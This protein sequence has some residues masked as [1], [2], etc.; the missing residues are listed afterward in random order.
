[1]T[2]QGIA[3]GG[4]HRRLPVYSTSIGKK[5]AKL[6]N[7]STDWMPVFRWNV[8]GIQRVSFGSVSAMEIPT[9]SFEIDEGKFSIKQLI[10]TLH[11]GKSWLR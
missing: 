10:I 5:S 3:H 2:N 1:V 6:S 11:V 7:Y 4:I 8:P 9:V